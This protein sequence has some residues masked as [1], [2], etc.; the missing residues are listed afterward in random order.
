M[1]WVWDTAEHFQ[2]CGGRNTSLDIKISGF[3]VPNL[4]VISCMILFCLQLMILKLASAKEQ[5]ICCLVEMTKSKIR[6][7]LD[8]GTVFTS[9]RYPVNL[10]L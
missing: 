4:P 6:V 1:A 7:W 8:P 3:L 2:R 9:F 10:M 5:G